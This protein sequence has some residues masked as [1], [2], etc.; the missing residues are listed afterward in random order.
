MMRK[1]LEKMPKEQEN[2]RLA[3]SARLCDAPARLYEASLT[4]RV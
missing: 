1:L 3:V 4:Q 2:K